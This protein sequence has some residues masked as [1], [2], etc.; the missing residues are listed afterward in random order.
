MLLN[1]FL[2][3]EFPVMQGGMAR[4]A[5]GAFAAAVSNAGSLGVIGSGGMSTERLERNIVEAKAA[6][7]RPFGVNIMLMADNIDEIATLLER[8][9]PAVV[10]TGAGSPAKYVGR[11]KAAGI[12]VIP[13]VPS[14]ALAIQMERAGA[15]AVIAEGTES[16]GHI[17]ETATLPLVPQV[18]DAVGIPV[19]AAGGIGNGRQL[20]AAFAMGAIGAQCGTIFLT[21]EECPIAPAYKE[22]VLKA[23]DTGTM[24]TGRSKH[25]PV[26]QIKNK[27]AKRYLQLEHEVADRAEL[28]GLTLGSLRRAVEE[29]DKDGGS[30]MAG[31]VAGEL[32]EI[33][34]LRQLLEDLMAGFGQAQADLQ[35]ALQEL[36]A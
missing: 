30:F 20:L 34:P 14:V 15:D 36:K 18:V 19:I 16:G 13:V 35:K 33:K 22:M 2:G 6:T 11:W 5:S 3:I 12:K 25:A 10:T 26:R 24:V 28:E 29:G 31:Q 8:E 23:R 27:M 17:G 21:S 1:E 7:D 9:R 32:H 4:V